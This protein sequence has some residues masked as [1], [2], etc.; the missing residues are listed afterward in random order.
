LLPLLAL[1]VI[2]ICFTLSDEMVIT[3]EE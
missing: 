3:Q 1:V 2:K